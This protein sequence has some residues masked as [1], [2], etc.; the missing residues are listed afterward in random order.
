MS[1][2]KK[3]IRMLEALKYINVERETV[4]PD[5]DLSVADLSVLIKVYVL[6]LNPDAPPS[7]TGISAECLR[8]EKCSTL[9]V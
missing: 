6:P 3:T 5:T 7:N 8:V 1:T 4:K 2:D 9:P